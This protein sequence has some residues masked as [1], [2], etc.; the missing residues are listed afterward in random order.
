MET[1]V[2]SGKGSEVEASASSRV[3]CRDRQRKR[4]TKVQGSGDELPESSNRSSTY[5]LSK[6]VRCFSILERTLVDCS[7]AR[8]QP[9]ASPTV[10]VPRVPDRLPFEPDV[11][12][13]AVGSQVWSTHQLEPCRHRLFEGLLNGLGITTLVGLSQPFVGLNRGIL[14]TSNTTCCQGPTVLMGRVAEAKNRAPGQHIHAD[15]HGIIV[16]V[17][18]V[19]I[20]EEA[21]P[22]GGSGVAAIHSGQKTAESKLTEDWYGGVV[23]CTNSSLCTRPGRTCR[24]PRQLLW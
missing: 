11:P 4:S 2:G 20:P 9:Q 17:A 18:P 22:G 1:I 14:R 10:R 12:I 21:F 8:R 7:I 23:R 16:V 24:R 15:L 19:F 3:S 5:D 13:P 6:P